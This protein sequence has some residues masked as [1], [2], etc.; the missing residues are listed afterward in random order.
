M[1]SF[2]TSAS[3]VLAAVMC[4][5][6]TGVGTWLYQSLP[7]ALEHDGALGAMLVIICALTCVLLMAFVGFLLRE[8][9]S[10]LNRDERLHTTARSSKNS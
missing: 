6:M 9:I 7:L 4:V 3:A 10:E 5:T 2:S 1:P 8:S